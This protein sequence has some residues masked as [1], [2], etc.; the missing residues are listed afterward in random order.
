MSARLC[1]TPPTPASGPTEHSR[2][3]TNGSPRGCSINRSTR[4]GSSAP[5]PGPTPTRWRSPGGDG[6]ARRRPPTRQAVA[7]ARLGAGRTRVP[8]GAT[9]GL[10]PIAETAARCR[11]LV[12]QGFGRLKLKISPGHDVI[13]VDAVLAGLGAASD[14]IELQVD[15]NAGY[16]G[17]EEARSTMVKLAERG[18][19]VVEQPFAR[20]RRRSR[21]TAGR[22]G[23]PTRSTHPD[24]CRRGGDLA[25]RRG[26][27]DRRR[28][29]D[30]IA[31]KPPRVGG[32]A[33]AADL[34]RICVDRGVAA[35]AGGMLETGLGRHALAAGGRPAGMHVDRRPVTGP[36]MVGR[37]P[38]AG[39]RTG[40]RH[41]HRAIGA[42]DRP[43]TSAH[44]H[45][46]HTVQRSLRTG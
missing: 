36:T 34:H 45:R 22:G 15:G 32:L 1:P 4:S 3:S 29:R 43:P 11:A 2:S 35:T 24:R 44:R 20:R 25:L 17:D 30:G 14:R 38:L 21:G 23:G 6:V 10:G 26:R 28:R 7:A 19:V 18:V 41:D 5:C 13:L 12:D 46:L 8:A 31:I 40:D 37:R 16:P 33:A 9:V 39:S 42:G 27:P